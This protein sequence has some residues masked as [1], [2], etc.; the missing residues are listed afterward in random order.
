MTELPTILLY[1]H[2]QLR[3]RLAGLLDLGGRCLDGGG[4]L[5]YHEHGEL[6]SC[7]CPAEHLSCRRAGRAACQCDRRAVE[8]ERFPPSLTPPPSSPSPFPLIV[9]FSSSLLVT[10]YHQ[11]NMRQQ[12]V[13]VKERTRERN[14]E[15][16]GSGG[17][18]RTL[19]ATPADR[20]ALLLRGSAE[21]HS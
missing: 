11:M 16:A 14:D 21:I 8:T 13:V 5:I 20:R 4:R 15:L 7:S 6:A 10:R 12:P 9:F 17:G 19:A 1:R 2:G 3:H 18:A